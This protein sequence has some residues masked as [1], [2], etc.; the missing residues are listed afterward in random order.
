MTKVLGISGSLR[1]SSCNSALLRAR[2]PA[3]CRAR[4]GVASIR[5]I[6]SD[7]DIERRASCGVVS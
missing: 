4:R 3:S 2:P 5:G 1:R 7:G 6:R